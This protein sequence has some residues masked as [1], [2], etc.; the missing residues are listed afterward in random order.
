MRLIND[1]PNITLGELT[2][3]TQCTMAEARIARFN[4]EL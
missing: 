2:H 1:Q 3:L 4:I